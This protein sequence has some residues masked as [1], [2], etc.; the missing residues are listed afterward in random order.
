[1]IFQT[2]LVLLEDSVIAG[3]CPNGNGICYACV[4]VDKTLPYWDGSNCVSCAE[5]LKD[6]DS[7]FSSAENTCVSC[8]DSTGKLW[9]SIAETCVSACPETA[10]V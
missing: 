9:N 1:M 7:H 3:D 10:P 5:A 8:S 6:V 2:A 4:V